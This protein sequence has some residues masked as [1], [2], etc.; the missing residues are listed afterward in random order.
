MNKSIVNFKELN[1]EKLLLDLYHEHF[2]KVRNT[3]IKFFYYKNLQYIMDIDD[4]TAILDQAFI[5]AYKSYQKLNHQFPFEKHFYIIAKGKVIDAYRA[6]NSNKKKILK[7]AFHENETESFL[8]DFYHQCNNIDDDEND[9]VQANKS[10][11]MKFIRWF[12]RSIKGNN[13]NKKILYYKFKYY[14][15]TEIA[16]ILNISKRIISKHWS[17][18]INRMRVQYQYWL[19]VNKKY[20]D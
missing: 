7:L 3:I 10:L 5:C 14:N 17:Y 18:L 9:W 20:I 16:N 4:L 6:Y 15:L 12:Y 19:K 2:P 8:A 1:Q 11:Q 13:L